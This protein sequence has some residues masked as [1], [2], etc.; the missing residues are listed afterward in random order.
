MK[1]IKKRIEE[2]KRKEEIYANELQQVQEIWMRMK[3]RY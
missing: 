3:R 2:K 1:Y